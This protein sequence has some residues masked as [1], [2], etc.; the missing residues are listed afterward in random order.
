M[1]IEN[2]EIPVQ[3]IQIKNEFYGHDPLLKCKT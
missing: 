1:N 2:T 3:E